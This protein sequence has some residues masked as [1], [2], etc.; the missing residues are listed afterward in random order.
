MPPGLSSVLLTFA[1]TLKAVH[2]FAFDFAKSANEHPAQRSIDRDTAQMMLKVV[3]RNRWT[4]LNKFIEFLD[5]S[6]AKVRTPLLSPP[7]PPPLLLLM[8][9]QCVMC[10]PHPS[11]KHYC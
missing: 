5:R 3:L 10:P 9:P 4:A 8:L 7:Q 1:Q 11:L 6:E 2:K